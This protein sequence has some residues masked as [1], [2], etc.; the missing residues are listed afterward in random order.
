MTRSSPA[1]YAPDIAARRVAVLSDVHGNLVALRAVLADLDAA[2]AEAI[3]VAGDMVNFGPSSSEVVDLLRARGAHLIRGNHE[4]EY[5]A[6]YGTPAM[7]E[8]WGAGPRYSC[9]R[10]TMRAL[11]G[12]RRGFL[13][14]LPDRLWLDP[15]TVVAH[16]SP[17]RVREAV[18][19]DTPEER[20]AEMLPEPAIRLAVVGHTHRPLLRELPARPERPSCRF[21][22]VGA[23]GDPLDGDSRASYAL[24]E[25]APSATPGDW[26][27]TLRRVPYDLEA[28]LAAYD[29]GLRQA[30][31]A[32]VELLT[33]QLRT[34]RP[35]FGP[36]VH[37]LAEVTDDQ[38]IPTL[39]HYLATHP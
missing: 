38:V 25:R 11:G 27:V 12:E 22:N 31:P 34:G 15:A 2:G 10:W 39:E 20:L 32:F 35:Y 16:G 23:V 3:V 36:A 14:G 5:V 26:R 8:A 37:A 17:R 13:A 19:A 9:L 6:Q 30:C 4:A 29:G 24:L 21:L 7:P 1:S 18:R 33:R 28:A